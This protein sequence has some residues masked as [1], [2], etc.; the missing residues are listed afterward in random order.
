MTLEKE[1]GLIIDRIS[2]LILLEQFGSLVDF[3]KKN[4]TENV[5]DDLKVEKTVIETPFNPTTTTKS[6]KERAVV[7]KRLIE[8]ISVEFSEL[9]NKKVDNLKD[10]LTK[11]FGSGPTFKQIFRK[12]LTMLLSYYNAFNTYVKQNYP[13]YSSSMMAFHVI[14]KQIDSYK[15]SVGV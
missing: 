9:W 15:K 5:T 1:L 12:L 10:R 13:A 6:D 7:D 4:A 2:E 8:T 14:M 11:S 3:V